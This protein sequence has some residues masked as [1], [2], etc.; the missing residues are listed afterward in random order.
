[1]DLSSESGR[2]PYNNLGLSG[3]PPQL[4]ERKRQSASHLLGLKRYTDADRTFLV[5]T[6][7]MIERQTASQLLELK[8]YTASRFTSRD[9]LC[10]KLLRPDPKTLHMPS[11]YHSVI[12]QTDVHLGRRTFSQHWGCPV[13]ARESQP[14]VANATRKTN[15]Q[16]RL[17]RQ[18][19]HTGADRMERLSE[20]LH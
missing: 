17:A 5:H 10:Q 18:P 1:M 20:V 16:E 14:Q 19:R 7:V 4:I 13:F 2:P 9:H 11:K 6:T 8:R 3:A 12:R 15:I